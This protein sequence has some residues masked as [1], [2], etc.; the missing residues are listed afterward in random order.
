MTKEY[1]HH[2]NVT[3]K[4]WKLEIPFFTLPKLAAGFPSSSELDSSELDSSFFAG[5]FF[6]FPNEKIQNQISPL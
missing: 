3:G 4:R 6:T 1:P 2:L 5:V